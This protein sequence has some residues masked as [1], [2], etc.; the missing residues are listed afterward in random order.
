MAR[1]AIVLGVV[2]LG[3]AAASTSPPASAAAPAEPVERAEALLFGAAINRFVAKQLPSTFSVR[4]DRDAGIGAADVTLVDARYCGS[5]KAGQGRLVGVVRPASS[6]ETVPAAMPPLEARDCHGKLE[7]VARRLAAAPAVGAVGVVELTVEWVPSEVRVSIGDVAAGGDGAKAIARTLARAK[8]AGPLATAETGGLKLETERGSSL[9]FDLALS[10]LKDGVLA[11]FTVACPGC[12]VPAPRA[13]TIVS[14]SAPADA[15]GIVGANLR[16]ANRVVALFSEDGPLVLEMDR[17]TVEL[18]NVQIAGGEGTLSVRGRAT[19]RAVAETALVS[20]ESSGADLRLGEMRAEPEL[21]NCA[22]QAGGAS[23]RC[24][25]R[26]A[27]RGPAAAALAAAMTSRYRG[28]LL[29]ALIVPPPFS[30]DVGGRRLTLRLTPTRASATGGS[31]VVT[32][33]AEVE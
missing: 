27:A 4:G 18:R 24:N 28:K 17:Q 5:T 33:K 15:D 12:A 16:L 20:I 8:I 19:S 1:R 30:F 2:T 31:V 26:N 21:E 11:T 32:G 7:E 22:A 10:F 13:P 23:M 9:A 3:L 25:I 29:R 6:G 14:A